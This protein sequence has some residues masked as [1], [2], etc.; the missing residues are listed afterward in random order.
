M[1]IHS[2]EKL[3]SYIFTYIVTVAKTESHHRLS[4]KSLYIAEK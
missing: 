1:T 2:N 3:I 4:K